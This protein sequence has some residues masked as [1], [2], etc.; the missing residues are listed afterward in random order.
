MGNDPRSKP[1]NFTLF[2]RILILVVFAYLTL[3]NCVL[4]EAK[5]S[6]NVYTFFF[7]LRRVY[8]HLSL[9]HTL[10]CLG[11][12]DASI[13][14]LLFGLICVLECTSISHPTRELLQGFLNRNSKLKPFLF[15]KNRRAKFNKAERKIGIKFKNLIPKTQQCLWLQMT[16]DVSSPSSLQKRSNLAKGY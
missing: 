3:E 13:Y 8:V 11:K 16:S 7:L 10:S 9:R 4:M 14:L 5:N 12:N 1:W 2:S 6:S 15:S